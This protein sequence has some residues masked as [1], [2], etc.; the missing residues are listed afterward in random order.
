MRN[1]FGIMRNVYGFTP[2]SPPNPRY[3]KALKYQGFSVSK[4]AET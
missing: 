2:K 3:E 4:M 1:G